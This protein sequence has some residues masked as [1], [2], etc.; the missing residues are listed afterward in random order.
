MTRTRW[1]TVTV[2][3]TT[4]LVAACGGGSSATTAPG[5]KHGPRRRPP[6]RR[7]PRR[8]GRRPRPRPPRPGAAPA[9]EAQ[10]PALEDLSSYKFAIGMAAE[11]TADFSL[12]PAGGSMTISGT[13]IVEAGDRHGHDHDHHGQA[14]GPQTAFGY[15]IV[16]RQ[17]VRQ[18][19]PGRVDGDLGR[20][21]PEHHRRVQARE[22]HEQLRQPGQR[23]RPSATRPRT[24]SRRTHYKGEAPTAMGAVFGLPDRHLDHGGL[25]RQG[26]RVPGL[27]RAHRRGRPTGKFTMTMDITDLDSPDNKV[28]AP[29]TFTPMGG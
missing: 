2:L 28:E 29:A 12:V 19:R 5:G 10:S 15:R 17:G 16:G 11:G 26:G 9:S 27:E 25:G 22:V 4:L 13:V 1:T 6:R 20:G 7:R 24:A 18:P 8:H 14:S 3:A 21:R 23:C